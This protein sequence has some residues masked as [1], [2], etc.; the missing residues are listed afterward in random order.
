MCL[1]RKVLNSCPDDQAIDN[2]K[3]SALLDFKDSCMGRMAKIDYS[4]GLVNLI[5]NFD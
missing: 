2:E 4:L 3:C 1:E 5:L